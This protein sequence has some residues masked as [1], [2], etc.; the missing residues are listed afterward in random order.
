MPLRSGAHL[1]LSRADIVSGDEGQQIG[2]LCMEGR[3]A[4]IITAE[5]LHLYRRAKV[6]FA[7]SSESLGSRELAKKLRTEG[8]ERTRYHMMKIM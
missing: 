3:F 7:A 8:F 5:E 1:P 2:L 4:R 6:L